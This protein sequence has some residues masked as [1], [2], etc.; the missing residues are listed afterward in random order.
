MKDPIE[1]NLKANKN[2]ST[3]FRGEEEMTNFAQTDT[4][5][6]ETESSLVKENEKD[7]TKLK[8][9]PLQETLTVETDSS[10]VKE[11]DETELSLKEYQKTSTESSLVKSGDDSTVFQRKDQIESNNVQ[12]KNKVTNC[13]KTSSLSLESMPMSLSMSLES[14]PTS[15]SL[16]SM[17][18]SMSLESTPTEILSKI[19]SNLATTDLLQNVASVSQ[20]FSKL[21]NSSSVHINVSF[22]TSV[23]ETGAVGFLEKAILMKKLSITEPI[24]FDAVT[25]TSYFPKYERKNCDKMLEAVID[26][27]HLREINSD[28]EV[29]VETL[30]TLNRSKW[31]KNISRLRLTVRKP[32]FENYDFSKLRMAFRDFGN[33]TD[34]DLKLDNFDSEWKEINYEVATNSRHKNLKS[35]TLHDCHHFY[36]EGGE[37]FP[38]FE[39]ED[40]VRTKKETLEVF[41]FKSYEPTDFTNFQFGAIQIICDTLGGRGGGL[42]KVSPNITWG[43][44]GVSKNV[45]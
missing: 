3:V 12:P 14:M 29:S 39:F 6:V 10:P 13:K 21:S 7:E 11:N 31:W 16:E 4:L 36:E 24:L 20:Q 18:T 38:D 5:T 43:G 2:D 44:G 33:L 8:L 23:D 32:D 19:L 9:K 45:T 42:A 28:L 15:L 40:F 22:S 30:E 37:E 26:H 35:L 1:V 27:A 25:E 34:L 17:P 41:K